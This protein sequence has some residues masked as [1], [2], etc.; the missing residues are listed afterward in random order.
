VIARTPGI[1]RHRPEA[2]QPQIELIDE[3]GDDP[4][5]AFFVYEIVETLGEQRG[6]VTIRALDEST[7]G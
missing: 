7:H 6:L 5:R 2:Q 4:Y 3:H 1:R